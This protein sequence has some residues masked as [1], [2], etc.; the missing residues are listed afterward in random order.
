MNNNELLPYFNDLVIFVQVVNA[1]S[2][3]QA[4]VQLSLNT[5]AVSRAISRLEKNLK[6]QLLIRTTRQLNITEQGAVVY[7]HSCNMLQAAEN[8]VQSCLEL[9]EDL[10]GTLKIYSPRALGKIL[11]HPLVLAFMQ[12]YPQLKIIFKMEDRPIHLIEEDIDIEFCITDHPPAELMGREMMMIEQILCAS[13]QYVESH[14]MPQIPSELKAHRCISLSPEMIDTRWRFKSEHKQSSVDISPY[15]TVNN[16][17]SRLDAVLTNLGIA[18][19]PKFIAA[20]MLQ[21]QKIVQILPE[22]QLQTNY[23]GKVWMLYGATKHLPKKIQIF[24]DF[25]LQQLQNEQF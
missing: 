18:S 2:F 12:Q 9:N 6:T 8:A 10:T 24:R 3:T 25:I 5:S 22:W 19:V 20:P 1:G 11:L 14:G 23:A 15:Y 13:H 7:E 21:Q 17:E 16:A 4:A